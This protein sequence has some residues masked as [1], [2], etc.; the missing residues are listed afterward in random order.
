MLPA[1]EANFG[2]YWRIGHWKGHPRTPGMDFY[3]VLRPHFFPR[4]P[5]RSDHFGARS[6]GHFWI[7]SLEFGKVCWILFS[8]WE[9]LVSISG[10]FLFL[11]DRVFIY[12][13]SSNFLKKVALPGVMAAKMPVISYLVPPTLCSS[14]KYPYPSP[15]E[16]QRIFRGER[17]PK[18]CN[19]RGGGGGFLRIFP[20][21]PS[22]TGELSKTNSCSVEEAISYFA[23]NG[24]LKQKLYFSSMIF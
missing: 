13:W 2:H 14:R 7:I 20:G 5:I 24:L 10:T 15:H 1:R 18:G 22:K 23:V 6:F 8:N 3:T 21:A 9:S 12:R 4:A 17:G 11:W 19:L 16:G